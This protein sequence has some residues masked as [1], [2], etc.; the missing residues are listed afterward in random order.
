VVTAQSLDSR[1]LAYSNIKNL[2]GATKM[3]NLSNDLIFPPSAETQSTPAASHPGCWTY[4][5]FAGAVAWIVIATVGIQVV[6]W[7][8]DQ[9][10]LIEEIPIPWYAW[11]LI[12]WGHGFVLVL[13]FV[14]K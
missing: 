14:Q 6:E 9:S 2:V 13:G 4:A 12:S 11:P 10:L 3:G 1:S 5:L 8:V 7:S